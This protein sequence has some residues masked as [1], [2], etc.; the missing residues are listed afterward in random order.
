MKKR[1]ITLLTIAALAIGLCGCG[2]TNEV[3]DIAKTDV[4]DTDTISEKES[5]T[6]SDNKSNTETNTE[7]SDCLIQW[8]W[9]DMDWS[10][11]KEANIANFAFF[12]GDGAVTPEAITSFFQTST[13]DNQ[14]PDGKRCT[15][16]YSHMD[17]DGNLI[18]RSL[19][20]L[21][22]IVRFDDETIQLGTPDADYGTTQLNVFNDS[23]NEVS[24]LE[25]L[26]NGMWSIEQTYVRAGK[27][28]WFDNSCFTSPLDY[29]ADACYYYGM[30]D[31]VIASSDAFSHTPSYPSEYFYATKTG[32]FHICYVFDDCVVGIFSADYHYQTED[33][34]VSTGT[35]DNTVSITVY[36]KEYWEKVFDSYQETDSEIITGEELSKL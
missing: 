8:W 33:G 5:D 7:D 26:N 9:E 22:C 25:C 13:T 2:D 29:L 19:A 31:Y 18:Y 34:Q 28:G 23:D 35:S 11:V 27:D 16:S 3:S 12:G 14:T 20:D 1:V 15:N 32:Y 4:S 6:E 24:F 36:G 30:P 17:D 10:K 21:I